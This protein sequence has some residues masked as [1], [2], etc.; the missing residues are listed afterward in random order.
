VRVVGG[1]ASLSVVLLLSSS[2]VSVWLLWMTTHAMMIAIKLVFDD[3]WLSPP[4][5]RPAH[6]R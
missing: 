2:R 3:Q 6:G 1:L 4:S 5:A